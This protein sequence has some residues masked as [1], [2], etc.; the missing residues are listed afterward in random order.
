MSLWC[1]EAG[2]DER[3]PTAAVVD[4]MQ[5]AFWNQGCPSKSVR[6]DNPQVHKLRVLKNKDTQKISAWQPP[7]KGNELTP[8]ARL[9]FFF[10]KAAELLSIYMFLGIWKMLMKMQ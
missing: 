7:L 4:S 10:F 8:K 9:Y 3:F 5:Y 1:I 6:Y 2:R